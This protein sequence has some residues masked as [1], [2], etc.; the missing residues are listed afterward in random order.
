LTPPVPGTSFLPVCRADMEARGWEELDFLLVNGDAYVDHPSFGGAVIARVLEAGGF[1][2]GILPQPDWRD[3]RSYGSMGRP[4]L[5]VLVTS[6]NLDSML[7]RFT[8]AK[9]DRSRDSYSP[10]GRK[11]LRPDRAVIVY[12]NGIRQLWG[13]VPLVIGGVEASLRRFAHYD[14]WADKPRRSIL[15]DSGADLLVYGMGEAQIREIA[16]LLDRGV[17]IKDIRSVR[18]TM[19]KTAALPEGGGHV[20]LPSWEEAASDRFKF[21]EAFRLQYDEQDPF[22]GAAV[23]Q[24]SGGLW[25]VQNPPPVPLTSAE[26]DEIYGLPYTR[27]W[28]PMYE[29][30]GGV[31]AI[32]EVRFS[33]TSHRGCF[34]S[35]SFCAIHYHQGRII[36]A[37]S[38]ESLIK[39]ARLLTSLPDFKGYI[40]DVGG[41]TANFRIPSCKEQLSRGACRGKQCLHP[42]PCRHL[43][44]DHSDYI[45]L[46]RKLRA[47]PGVKKVFI[48][49]G[50]RFD[51]L[52]EDKKNNFLEE[53]CEYHVSGQLKIAP[54]H[55]SP[56]VLSLMGKSRPEVYVKFMEAYARANKKL[57]KKQYL[58]PYFISSHP[59]AELKDAALLA[60]FL[61]DIKYQPEQV[62][63]FIPT[64][65]SLSTCI[66]YSGVDPFSGKEVY[67]PKSVRERKMQR[68]LLQYGAPENREMVIRALQEAGREDLIGD[69]PKCLVRPAF[70]APDRGGGPS[71]SPRWQ[72]G[73]KGAQPAKAR[74]RS[75][76]RRRG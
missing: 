31:P 58:V 32:E 14:Y 66:Y 42:A 7:N 20:R 43:E 63:D 48:R 55:V 54:E 74:P 26:M 60:E 61:R 36:Q 35:C 34:G 52:L 38:H 41:P 8:A 27:T 47:L 50:V 46:L 40:H 6:G 10:G 51:Y 19:Y 30:A 65:G 37:R 16:S 21:A 59:G 25:A 28:H 23:A 18:G 22:H 9:K 76:G 15:I 62:Q 39:E 45:A 71:P 24:K 69:G 68:A 29:S 12:C 44:A 64:P 72:G 33:L 1:R 4:R 11:G 53:L 17:S 57:G 5:A 56:R 70:R 3:V 2:V 67:V 13:D 75:G 73:R 49:S